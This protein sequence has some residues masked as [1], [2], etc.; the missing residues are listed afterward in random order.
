MADLPASQRRHECK[1]H[2]GPVIVVK[3]ACLLGKA[4]HIEH[5]IIWR[6]KG[7]VHRPFKPRKIGDVGILGKKPRDCPDE[8]FADKI[9]RPAAWRM[10]DQMMRRRA[11]VS[12]LAHP[13]HRLGK[14]SRIASTSRVR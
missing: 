3:P 6:S 7:K 12:V 11:A 1:P 2:C 9:E 14:V 8:S 10:L 4:R 5:I 13:L